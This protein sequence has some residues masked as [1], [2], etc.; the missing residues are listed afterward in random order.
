MMDKLPVTW[1]QFKK[2]A[3][4]TGILLPPHEPYWGIHDDHPAVFVTWEE[5]KTYCEWAG[6]R[7][8]AEAE[9]EKGARGTDERKYPHVV[10]GGSWD[11]RPSVLSASCCNWAFR[12]YREGDFGFRYAMNAP[13]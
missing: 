3:E 2:F 10:R 7:L 9:R 4:A 8:P 13:K 1:R 5:A 11:S 12:G 6:G